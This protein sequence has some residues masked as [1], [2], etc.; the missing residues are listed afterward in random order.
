MTSCI[1]NG[2]H[3]KGTIYKLIYGAATISGG[4]HASRCLN[5]FVRDENSAPQFSHFDA[6]LW[7]VSGSAATHAAHRAYP[8]SPARGTH[9]AA[10]VPRTGPRVVPPL[11]LRNCAAEKLPSSFHSPQAEHCAGSV[12]RNAA[13][14]TVIFTA[15]I[16][17]LCTSTT[18]GVS[19]VR[20]LSRGHHT[21]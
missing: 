7:V 5:N 11:K 8:A 19:H 18:F 1:D 15:R 16:P 14:C 10:G 20:Q 6:L 4:L 9:C 17:R 2:K 21:V 3:K 13:S 12:G